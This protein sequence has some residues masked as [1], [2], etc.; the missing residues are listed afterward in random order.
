MSLPGTRKCLSMKRASVKTWNGDS[1]ASDVG[2]KKKIAHST[3]VP[4]PTS[5]P[6]VPGACFA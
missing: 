2:R 1:P 4:T 3:I 6:S 5:D